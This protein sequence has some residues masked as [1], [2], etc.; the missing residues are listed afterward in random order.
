[1]ASWKKKPVGS[2]GPGGFGTWPAHFS[3]ARFEYEI[4]EKNV[5]RPF[6]HLSDMW[7]QE[8]PSRLLKMFLYELNTER[9]I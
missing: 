2:A 1:M 6:F 9:T 5:Y 8:R 4:E 7:V 3:G